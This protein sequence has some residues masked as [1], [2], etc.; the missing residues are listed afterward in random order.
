MNWLEDCS[1]RVVDTGFISRW[2]PVT[3]DAQGS[4]LGPVCF[5]ILISNVDN[6]IECT[7]SKFVH[8]TKL[9]GAVD[10]TEGRNAIQMDLDPCEPNE[11]QRG[12][13]QAVALGL[14]QSRYV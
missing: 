6:E 4:V 12:Q 11:V 3:S 9:S 7:L 5:N 13:V 1:Q 10:M 8:D 14:E 2:R